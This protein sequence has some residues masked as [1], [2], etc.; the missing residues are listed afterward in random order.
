MSRTTFVTHYISPTDHKIRLFYNN[1]KYKKGE[2]E[3]KQTPA[4]DKMKPNNQIQLSS[5]F[6]PKNQL[7]TS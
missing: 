6:R 4:K 5:F 3:V 7:L 1:I 2:K